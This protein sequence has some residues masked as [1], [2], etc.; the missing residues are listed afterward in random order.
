MAGSR[1]EKRIQ[2][3]IA[4]IE[5]EEKKKEAKARAQKALAE[6]T[7]AFEGNLYLWVSICYHF[8]TAF[9]LHVNIRPVRKLCDCYYNL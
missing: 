8:I 2:E 1:E 4:R 7:D 5:R 6:A 9:V 3:Y